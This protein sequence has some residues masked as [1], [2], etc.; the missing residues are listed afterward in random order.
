MTTEITSGSPKGSPGSPRRRSARR[1][2]PCRGRGGAKGSGPP[3]VR[4]REDP[5]PLYRTAGAR[6]R[7]GDRGG[8]GGRPRYCGPDDAHGRRQ[9]GDMVLVAGIADVVVRRAP[10][11]IPFP[12]VPLDTVEPEQAELFRQFPVVA[13]H[14]AAFAGGD[15]LDRVERIDRDVA[16]SSGGLPP[17]GSAH[18]GGGA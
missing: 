1:R 8:R 7:A 10:L 4:T 14:H 17:V 13:G 16:V 11:P 3:P 5:L 6:R 15:V 9:V 18:G 2:R 12:G